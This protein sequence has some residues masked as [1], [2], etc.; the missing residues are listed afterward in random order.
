[1]STHGTA[2]EPTTSDGPGAPAPERTRS[3]WW[4][5]LLGAVGVVAVLAVGTLVLGRLATSD[6]MALVLTTALFGGVFIALAI[7]VLRRRD[8]L[9]PLGAA[10][11]LSAIAV[12]VLVGIPMLRSTTVSEQVVSAGTPG[13]SVIASGSFVEVEHAGEGTATVVTRED[14]TT[15]LTLT[16]F[17]TDPGPDLLVYLTTD[18]PAVDGEIGEFVDLGRLKGN[19]G[20]Q[21]YQIPA[22]TDLSQFAHAVVWCR[23]FD[24]AF[25]TAAL[26]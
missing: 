2:G 19:K 7:L 5:K 22:G 18:D 10:F 11:A 23:A 24:V 8:L 4:L 9:V 3:P 17:S 12:T 15:W 13:A 16:G 1:M 26:A 6:T 21:Q 14:G 20:D 25:V